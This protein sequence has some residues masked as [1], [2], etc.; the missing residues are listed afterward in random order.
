MKTAILI[1]GY[2]RTFK[3]NL[4]KIKENIINKLKD[5]DVYIHLT[6]N[7]SKE[8]IYLNSSNLEEDINYINREINPLSL[9]CEEN[10]DFSDNKKINNTYNL[11]FKF[12]KL[13][14]LKKLNEENSNQKYELVIKYRPDLNVLSTDLFNQDFSKKIIYLPK[15]SVIDKNKLSKNDDNYICDIFAYGNSEVM[16]KY[17]SIYEY[18]D[19]L[20]QK[21]GPVSETIL[22]HHLVNKKI[23]FKQLDIDYNVILSS[24]NVFAICGDSGSGKTTLGNIL[25][26]YFSSSFMLECDRYHKWERND[27]NWKKFTHLNPESNFLT[28]MNQDIFDLK[29]GNTIYQVDYDHKTGKFT[30]KE[31][32]DSSDNIIVCGLH[33]LYTNDENIYDLK[34]YIDTEENLKNYWKINR[35]TKQRGYTKEKSLEQ[36][37]NRKEDYYKFIYPQRNKSDLIINFYYENLNEEEFDE[38]NISLKI[39]I[40]SNYDINFLIEKLQNIN[41]DIIPELKENFYILDFKKYKTINILNV[42]DLPV[43]NNFYDYIMF[44]IINLKKLNS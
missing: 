14:E 20:I 25:K 22:Y 21:Y 37:R 29:I 43:L 3:D 30:D 15:E 23:D 19:N 13:N 17:F 44:I 34:I 27:D 1:S 41:L 40:K 7:E 8:D 33:S 38:N 35:D 11:W 16:D 32:I 10:Y 31:I 26:K 42:G 12:Y 36:I 2:L 4:P 28:K 9:I 18:I 24:C 6:K 39:F 5:V